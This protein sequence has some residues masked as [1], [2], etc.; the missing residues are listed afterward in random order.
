MNFHGY[1]FKENDKYYIENI[2][3]GNIFALND[4]Y[5]RNFLNCDSKILN[6][7]E[8][9]KLLNLRN[10]LNR[11]SFD[12]IFIVNSKCNLR[13]E[14][15]FE[16]DNYL[17]KEDGKFNFINYV[18]RNYKDV[19]NITFTGGEP[20]LRF[21]LIKEVC[22]CLNHKNVINKYSIVTNGL[23]LNQ[24]NL[25]FLN[26]NYFSIQ[27]S[28]DGG[29]SDYN[30]KLDRTNKIVE[31][32][33]LDKIKFVL[34]QYTNIEISLRV[35]FSKYDFKS[36]KK[37]IDYIYT[38][39]GDCSSNPKLDIYFDFIDVNNKDDMWIDF[40]DKINKLVE[41]YEYLFSKKINTSHQYVFGGLCSAKDKDTIIIDSNGIEYPCYSFVGEND[42]N[43]NY[44]Y[45]QL[46][47]HKDCHLHD[48][49]NG[50]CVYSNYCDTNEF[51][52][53]C[54][55]EKLDFI[56]QYLFVYKLMMLNKISGKEIKEELNNVEIISINI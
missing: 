52:I 7:L 32:E 12:A 31:N 24:E 28:I 23:L 21:P 6:V 19:N 2:T 8:E 50:G 36:Y 54:H 55:K 46:N 40:D 14:Y 15:C 43:S 26:F 9:N 53:N 13:C 16:K 11:N 29:L 39:L 20:L 42:I 25:A 47:C 48:V 3:N 45:N 51:L 34:T 35:N 17:N 10:E 38:Y 56:I 37:K 44:D 30:S 22:D 41:L 1:A 18:N 33:I 49:C 4:I 27:L 5:Y